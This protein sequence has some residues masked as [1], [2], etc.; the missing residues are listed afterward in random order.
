MVDLRRSSLDPSEERRKVERDQGTH[1]GNTG[2]SGRRI[3]V[4]EI[5]ISSEGVASSS[6]GPEGR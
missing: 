3:Q 6:S 4:L 2:D 1:S 5:C